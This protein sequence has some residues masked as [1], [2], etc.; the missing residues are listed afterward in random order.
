MELEGYCTQRSPPLD[1]VLSQLYP[2][3]TFT[4]FFQNPF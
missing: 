4:S 1:P 3:N 2:E